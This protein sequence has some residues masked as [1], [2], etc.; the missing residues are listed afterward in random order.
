MVN[1][2]V[3]S[4]CLLCVSDQSAVLLPVSSCQGNGVS[5]HR[6]W[7][8]TFHGSAPTAFLRRVN[9]VSGLDWY[10]GSAFE[11]YF[12]TRFLMSA[13]ALSFPSCRRTDMLRRVIQTL[14]GVECICC[15]DFQRMF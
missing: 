3:E 6:G 5:C 9:Q 11:I 1:S 7:E 10:K 12:D 14:L 2:H 4:Y 8:Q 15:S 13:L